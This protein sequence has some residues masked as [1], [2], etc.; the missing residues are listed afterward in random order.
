MRVGLTSS[1][2]EVAQCIA[3][4]LQ[5]TKREWHG[6]AEDSWFSHIA[7]AVPGVVTSNEWLE[8]VVLQ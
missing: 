4:I 7:I 5:T 3:S 8:P 2:L 1:G 6:A